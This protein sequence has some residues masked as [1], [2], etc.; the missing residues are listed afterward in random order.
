MEGKTIG[1]EEMRE[2]RRKGEWEG[3]SDEEKQKGTK[4]TEERE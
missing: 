2:G 3:Q 4:R 1:K